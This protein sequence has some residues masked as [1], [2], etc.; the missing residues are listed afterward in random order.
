M[1]ENINNELNT[2]V[3]HI[4]LPSE[5]E[6]VKSIFIL[7]GGFGSGKTYLLDTL[8]N[9]LTDSKSVDCIIKI[10]NDNY[11]FLPELM[12][13]SVLNIKTEFGYIS[14]YGSEST[15]NLEQFKLYL[16]TLK[17]SNS[18][19]FN[20]YCVSSKLK[21]QFEWAE[22]YSMIK[23]QEVEVFDAVKEL[24]PKKGELRLLFETY[25]V[26]IESLIVDLM[27]SFY[28]ISDSENPV[29]NKT[30][31][32]KKV[33]LCLDNIDS[34]NGS[35]YYF[36]LNFVIP[37][38][39]TKTFGEF[40]SYHISFIDSNIKISDFF[41]FKVIISSRNDFIN[42]NHSILQNLLP[43]VQLVNL[44]YLSENHITDEYKNDSNKNID[45]NKIYN[46][47]KGI[48]LLL[49]EAAEANLNEFDYTKHICKLAYNAIIKDLSIKEIDYLHILA[50][51]D[52][53]EE[54]SL[55]Y[56]DKYKTSVNT[57]KNFLL[58]NPNLC[59]VD[60]KNKLKDEIIYYIYNY[61][62]VYN[63]FEYDYLNNISKA[64]KSIKEL[65]VKFSDEEFA[66]LKTIAYLNQYEDKPVMSL[67]LNDSLKIWDSLY[68]GNM[69]IFPN[70]KYKMADEYASKII[71]FVKIINIAEHNKLKGLY[72]NL[73]SKI[74]D[75]ERL[76]QSQRENQITE[77]NNT[78][79]SIDKEIKNQKNT[80]KQFQENL[81]KTENA[82]IELRR[83]I[84]NNSFQSNVIIASVNAIITL[85]I[86]AITFF[87]PSIADVKDSNSPVYSIQIILYCIAAVFGGIGTYFSIKVFKNLSNA[88]EMKLVQEQIDLLEIEKNQIQD[89]MKECKSYT[90][91]LKS[92]A[93]FIRK[94]L[95]E[96]D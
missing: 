57:L 79:I 96:L 32:R 34:I 35:I 23:A 91:E 40:I 93:A 84:T 56:F 9:E 33:V 65:L 77:F 15:Y 18:S 82:M 76:I 92:K 52:N 4:N 39:Y 27:N 66:A 36:F 60:D 43:F 86:L 21:S 6:D 70:S 31:D 14:E 17:K 78:L 44:N 95:S 30:G 41:D 72:E 67:A 89:N 49:S 55:K 71:E 37:Y 10:N 48:P 63:K 45:L 51:I 11:T 87:L 28:P 94:Q 7:S 1:F 20:A 90:E 26:A 22:N 64:V 16:D 42:L 85:I 74:K 25:T 61:L 8:T 38:C 54:R 2:I 12:H 3:S 47:S 83:R 46:I 53:L 24:F 58:F 75:N 62:L 29:I 5:Q 50:F 80:C 69:D 68:K 19:M 88:A 13:S 59:S 81:M 73:A